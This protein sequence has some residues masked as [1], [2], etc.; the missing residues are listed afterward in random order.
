[1]NKACTNCD[2][3]LI[4]NIGFNPVI[5]PECNGRGYHTVAEKGKIISYDEYIRMCEVADKAEILSICISRYICAG[6]L[7]KKTIRALDEL[8]IAL[9]RYHR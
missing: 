1:M 3:G 2:N 5:C 8:N 7:T 4:Y 9:R 6:G